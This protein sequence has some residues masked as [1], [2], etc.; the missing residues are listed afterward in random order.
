LEASLNKL[1]AGQN[2]VCDSSQDAAGNELA[3][4]RTA[5]MPAVDGAQVV[6]TID[7]ALQQV[8]EQ[9]LAKAMTQYHPSNA[10]CVV[11]RPATG[12][13]LA[14]AS[15]P[16]FL[17]QQPG[18]SGPA[19][20]RNH[21]ISDECEVGSVFKVIT[22]ATALDRG[23]VTLGQRI[24]C[25][26]GHWTYQH[27]ALRDDDHHYGDL[28]VG[29]CLAKSSNIG[30]AKIGLL[31]GA[32]ALYNSILRF[33]FG[34]RTGVP[35]GYET[36][37]FIRPPARW[38]PASITRIAIGHEL[39]VSQLQLAMAY[40]AIANDGVL[41]R[42]LL[43]KAVNHA[44][45][46]RW[47]RYEPQA[48]R[49]VVRPETARLVREAM[50]GVVEHGTGQLAALPGYSVAGKTGTAQKSDGHRYLAGHYY[51]SFVGM[52]PANK[53]ELVIAV[54]VDDPGN[55]AYGGTVAAPIFRE[56]GTKAV[57]FYG[58]EPDV[59]P[60]PARPAITRRPNRPLEWFAAAQ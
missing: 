50:R 26:N 8:V 7:L 24:F 45:G 47:G 40:A 18:G 39:T 33:G 52:V 23:A 21:V 60:I 35:L 31:V 27:T 58:I 49:R 6:L 46:S 14:L 43:V 55:S 51:C 30:F 41:M 15:L 2:G 36:P 32:D 4:C 59:A 13:I 5:E 25:E 57:A 56:I 11:I 9:A 12:E 53:A 28:T 34:N 22:L 38:T 20:W 3:F 37:G 48:I 10:S 17:P 42:P 54:A 19:G 1:L 16:G 29:D 44:D